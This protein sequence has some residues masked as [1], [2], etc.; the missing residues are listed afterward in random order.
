MLHALDD[1]LDQAREAV[2]AGDFPALARLAPALELEA[3][4]LPRQDRETAARLLRKAER[5]A[6]LLTAAGRG[7][8]AALSRLDAIAAGPT[9]ATYDAQGRKAALSVEPV[10]PVRRA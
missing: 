10:G 2:L 9:L 8:K 3:G 4:R 7:V 1:L 6:S 5:N